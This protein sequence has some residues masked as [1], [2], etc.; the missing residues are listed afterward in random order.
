MGISDPERRDVSCVG[1]ATP[2]VARLRHLNQYAPLQRS[3]SSSNPAP[4]K[5]GSSSKR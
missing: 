5:G 2:A 4:D 3:D 1:A